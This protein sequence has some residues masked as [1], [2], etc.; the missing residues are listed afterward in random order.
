MKCE[1]CDK[2]LKEDSKSKMCEECIDKYDRIDEEKDGKKEF[3]YGIEELDK[4][5]KGLKKAINNSTSIMSMDSDDEEVPDEQEQEAAPE[6]QGVSA[7]AE[8]APAEDS[9]QEAPEGGEE[10]PAEEDPE[11]V[12]QRLIDALR[13]EG[14]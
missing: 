5:W 1:K 8:G 6:D 3:D 2:M 11:E 10:Q 12:N 14:N 13:K 4:R 7:E 9:E